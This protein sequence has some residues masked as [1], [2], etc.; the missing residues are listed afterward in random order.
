MGLISILLIT[1]CFA[2]VFGTGDSPLSPEE[3]KAIQENLD[4]LQ[5][6]KDFMKAIFESDKIE[7]RAEDKKEEC[8]PIGAE[9]N[10]WTGPNC[11]SIRTR[12]NVFDRLENGG[13]PRARWR[14]A[15]R[16]Y[17]GGVWLDEIYNFFKNLG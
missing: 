1:I 3:R 4:K 15:C 10:F 11:C 7:K 14:S 8:L 9:C 12:C 13:T 6:I 2:S 5:L 16:E 17:N